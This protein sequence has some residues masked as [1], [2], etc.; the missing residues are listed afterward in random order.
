MSDIECRFT[1]QDWFS[2][3]TTEWYYNNTLE[4]Y[5]DGVN[6]LYVHTVDLCENWVEY[7]IHDMNGIRLMESGEAI[8]ERSYGEVTLKIRRT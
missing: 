7:F 6:V 2:L 3:F 1:V 8:C 4:V 5:L